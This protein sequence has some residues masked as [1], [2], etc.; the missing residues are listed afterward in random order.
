MPRAKL[1]TASLR[2]R[3]L[4]VAID[5]LVE[6]GAAGFTARRI[7]ESA[8]TSPA[9]IYEFFD[10]KAGLIREIFFD[11][12]RRLATRLNETET[13][14]DPITDL[15]A[16]FDTFRAFVVAEPKLADVMFSRPFAD[17]NPGPDEVAAG[18][19]TRE[20]IVSRVRRCVDAGLLQGDDTDIAHVV[21]ALAQGLALQETGGWLGTTEASVDRRWQL[22]FDLLVGQSN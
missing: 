16:I 5:T 12:F 20:C 21:L 1:R 3:I 4:H 7:A 15:A 19:A 2:E 18:T 9:A 22:A 17:F 8:G 14:D 11:G 6:D 13:S 10:D